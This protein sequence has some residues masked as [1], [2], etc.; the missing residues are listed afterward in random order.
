MTVTHNIGHSGPKVLKKQT[1]FLPRSLVNI[2]YCGEPPWP[3]GSV[4]GLRPPGL[5]FQIFY[6]GGGGEGSV[7][8]LISPSSGGS[9]GPFSL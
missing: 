8:S 9:P 1:M 6:L 3:R 7:I 2:N 5:E 4:L